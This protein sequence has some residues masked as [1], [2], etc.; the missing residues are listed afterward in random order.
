M[1]GERR[2]NW[3]GMVRYAA[4]SSTV[5][6]R[7]GEYTLKAK[8]TTND[9]RPPSPSWSCDRPRFPPVLRTVACDVEKQ[10]PSTR[11]KRKEKQ[12]P[13]PCVRFPLSLSFLFPPLSTNNKVVYSMVLRLAFV[14]LKHPNPIHYYY[15]ARVQLRDAACPRSLSRSVR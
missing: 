7:H 9:Q 4:A 3:M 14:F 10:P 6:S 11:Q 8:P 15:H 1:S 2:W 13:K 12:Q 5:D